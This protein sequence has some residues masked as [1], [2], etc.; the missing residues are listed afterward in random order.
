MDRLSIVYFVND[1]SL[2]NLQKI[3][4]YIATEEHWF[5][6]NIFAKLTESSVDAKAESAEPTEDDGNSLNVISEEGDTGLFWWYFD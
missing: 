5:F 3:L 6:V 4:H 2:W 1:F